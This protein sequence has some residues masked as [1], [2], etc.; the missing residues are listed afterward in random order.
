M[1]STT[2][3]EPDKNVA[4][5]SAE[6]LKKQESSEVDEEFDVFTKERVESV[7]KMVPLEPAVVVINVTKNNLGTVTEDEEKQDNLDGNDATKTGKDTEP[8]KENDLVNNKLADP[9]LN[10]PLEVTNKQSDEQ[11]KVEQFSFGEIPRKPNKEKKQ[12]PDNKPFLRDRSASIGALSLKTPIA[13]L[14]GEQNRTMLFQ[15]LI[16]FH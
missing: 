12:L 16:N 10:K 4:W 2:P 9:L 6:N 14:I 8:P 7:K 5:K 13:H 1:P 15:V 3:L 11:T